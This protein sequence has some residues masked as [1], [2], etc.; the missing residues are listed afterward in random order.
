MSRTLPFR[1]LD[2]FT[3]ERFRGNPLAVVLDAGG[4]ETAAMQAVAAEFNLSETVFV[5]TVDP[6]AGRARV[7]IFTPRSEL[8]FAGH[9]TVGTA[10]L[11]AREG[12]GIETAAGRHLVLEEAAGDVPVDIA[13]LGG[14]PAHARFT[15]PG[16]AT[17]GAPLDP[18]LVAPA[19]G[20]GR[21]DLAGVAPRAAGFGVPFLML[22]L[23]SLEALGRAASV[24]LPEPLLEAGLRHGAYLFTRATGDGSIRARLFAPLLGI[25][26]D[27]ATGAAAAG[28]AALLATVDPSSDLDGAWRIVQGVEMGRRSVIDITAEKRGGRLGRVTVAGG[29]VPVSAGRITV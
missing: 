18:G 16:T 12:L 17:V 19:F 21:D 20:L 29:A 10:L 9:P 25:A 8:P 7:R 2:V 14:Q 4:L 3:D 5:T 13:L 15:A 11:L 28:L 6:A 1:T 23:A 27:P 26:E 24:A 22:E